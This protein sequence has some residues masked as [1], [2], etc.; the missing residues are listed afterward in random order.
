MEK[1]NVFSNSSVCVSECLSVRAVT[2]ENIKES[3]IT[4]VARTCS[5]CSTHPTCCKLVSH[6]PYE[7]CMHT[8]PLDL[9]KIGCVPT[10]AVVSTGGGGILYPQIPYPLDTL[11]PDSLP[12]R[13]HT[14]S[15]DT[16][17][18]GKDR[19]PEIPYPLEGHG[20]KD[21]LHP[22]VNRMTNTRFWKHYLHATSL[23][24]G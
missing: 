7:I 14:P 10:A 3:Q 9:L 18:P 20:T 22:P 13:Y 12:L 23:A 24:V 8:A 6:V 15:P 21:T 16:Q 19:V 5:T 17:P 11:P 4:Q 1:G 2:I